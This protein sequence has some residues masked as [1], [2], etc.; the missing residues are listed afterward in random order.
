M[1]ICFKDIKVASLLKSNSKIAESLLIKSIPI[2]NLRGLSN[3]MARR[4]MRREHA[5]PKHVYE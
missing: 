2:R 4:R 1:C 5:R 3:V